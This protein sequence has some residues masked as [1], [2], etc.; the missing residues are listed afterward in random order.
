MKL[1]KWSPTCQHPGPSLTNP[2]ISGKYAVISTVQKVILR[3]CFIVIVTNFIKLEL[4]ID[5]EIKNNYIKYLDW[6]HA[7]KK[8][9]H[10]DSF[11]TQ[12]DD[13]PIIN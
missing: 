13:Q 6:I 5:L 12:S 7:Q 9:L 1:V 2:P 4:Q 3:V 10:F 11:Y 8:P